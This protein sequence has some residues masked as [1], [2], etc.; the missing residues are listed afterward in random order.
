MEAVLVS[1]FRI[2]AC[3]GFRNDVIIYLF[4]N[5]KNPLST[6]WGERV[7]VGVNKY[8]LNYSL[9]FSPSP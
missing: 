6:L 5:K 7:R 9:I 4:H 8:Q 1:G 3:G 2:S